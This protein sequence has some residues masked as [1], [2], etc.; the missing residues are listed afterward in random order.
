MKSESRLDY[1]EHTQI[2]YVAGVHGVR[3]S[4]KL[5][6][7]TDAPEYYMN[8]ESFTVEIQREL[9]ALQI[10]S[11]R[12]H[13]N[14]WITKFQGIESRNEAEALRGCR[15]FLE[16]SKLRPLAE[17]EVFY[18]QLIGCDVKTM[19]DVLVGQIVDILETGAND[20]Y[21]IKNGDS[22]VLIPATP[23]VIRSRNVQEKM[24]L[25][26]PFPGLLDDAI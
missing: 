14:Q 13:Q 2:A 18:H 20:V 6:L 11:I 15:V 7:M 23:E 10:E 9:Q 16:D 21:V 22:E 5:S 25:I 8:C 12:L 4:V 3:G 17:N 19:E 26:E 1:P 24:I